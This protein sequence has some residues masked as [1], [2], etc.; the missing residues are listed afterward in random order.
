M[1]EVPL[2]TLASDDADVLDWGAKWPARPLLG[3]F[4]MTRF[5]HFP[6]F[7]MIFNE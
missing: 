3:C 4:P 6:F 5:S 2:N 7:I 1:D